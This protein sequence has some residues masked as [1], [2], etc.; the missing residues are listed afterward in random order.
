MRLGQNPLAFDLY[1]GHVTKEGYVAGP[2]IFGTHG[3]YRALLRGRD[4]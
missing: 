3:G 4:A 1:G 2:K